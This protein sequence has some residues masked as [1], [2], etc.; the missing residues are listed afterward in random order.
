MYPCGVALYIL[1]FSLVVNICY[2]SLLR[3]LEYFNPLE[4]ICLLYVVLRSQF[5]RTFFLVQ[6]L[7]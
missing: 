4:K 1:L 7:T 3:P 5:H 2:S 6:T